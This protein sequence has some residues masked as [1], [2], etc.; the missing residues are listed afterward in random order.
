MKVKT[1]DWQQ[2]IPNHVR[3]LNVLAEKSG[4]I[5]SVGLAKNEDGEDEIS[6]KWTGKEKQFR[7]TGLLNEGCRFP[8]SSGALR[9]SRYLGGF[10]SNNGGVYTLAERD[11]LP[12]TRSIKNGVE[13]TE[14]CNGDKGHHGTREALIAAKIVEDHQFPAGGKSRPRYRK[15]CSPDYASVDESE[16]EWSV[17]TQPDGTFRHWVQGL[18]SRRAA[19]EGRKEWREKYGPGARAAGTPGEA[20]SEKLASFK[21]VDEYRGFLSK[22]IWLTTQGT[23]DSYKEI[24]TREGFIYKIPSETLEELNDG[25]CELLRLVRDA[26]ISVV[27][28]DNRPAE[29][30]TRAAD[31]V[32]GAATNRQLQAFLSGI[33]GQQR[34]SL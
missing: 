34:P 17:I 4:L 16:R 23:L 32:T 26:S 5:V 22:V 2:R 6:S 25:I 33:L 27:R 13:Y 15:D 7:N 9:G 29:E 12:I 21:S 31:L 28:L 8:L 10:L 20:I 1:Q 30:R 18:S 24:K 3:A 14:Y 19:I 11:A